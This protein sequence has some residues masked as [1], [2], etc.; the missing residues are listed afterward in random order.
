MSNENRD[1]TKVHSVERMILV[2][3][4]CRDIGIE[5]CYADEGAKMRLST[6]SVN[7]PG[8]L[9]AGFTDYFEGKRIQVLGNAEVYF[10]ENLGE[11]TR[12]SAYERLFS[13]KVPCVIFAHGHEVTPDI[14]DI[15]EHYHVPVMKS[16]KTTSDLI[17]DIVNYLN[18]FLAPDC[19]IHGVLMEI[20]GVGVLITGHSGL[21][22]SETALELVHRG[23]RLVADDAVIAKRVKNS[24]IGTSAENIKFFMEVRGIG[25]IDVRSMFGVG[26]VINDQEIQLVVE[27]EK[28]EE[29]KAYERLRQ[30]EEYMNIMGIDIPKVTLPV[31]AGRNL[32]IV[33]EVAARSYRL[34]GLGYD[35]Y[36]ELVKNIQRGNKNN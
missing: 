21:G 13:N 23:H 30:R 20:S 31:M 19:S 15:A 35:P 2:D 34:K 9:L 28:W 1:L 10:L 5:K 17:N 4:F 12:R 29:N 3:T 8:L 6:L 11:T 22:K 33:V 7:R 26:S 25:I 14:L 27:L 18:D 24:I 36:E 16:K 32:A